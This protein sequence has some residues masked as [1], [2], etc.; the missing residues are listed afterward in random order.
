M[1]G[2]LRLKG[3]RQATQYF[4]FEQGEDT[5]LHGERQRRGGQCLSHF[6]D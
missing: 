3:S 6:T 1:G 5:E 4:H 2:A